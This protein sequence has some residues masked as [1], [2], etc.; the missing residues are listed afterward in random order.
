MAQVYADIGNQVC[1]CT[2]LKRR[3]KGVCKMYIRDKHDCL[4]GECTGNIV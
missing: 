2:K 1:A 4:S 3:E